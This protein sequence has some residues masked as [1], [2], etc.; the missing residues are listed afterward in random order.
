[1]GYQQRIIGTTTLTPS[2]SID[3]S[4][5]R[6]DQVSEAQSF[7]S[8][9]TRLSFGARLK[10]DV[11][12]FYGGIGSFEAIRH[13]LSPS[14]SYSYAPGV[15][16]TDLQT[17]VFGSRE[18]QTKNVISLSLNQTFEAKRKAEE[19]STAVAGDSLE[20]AQAQETAPGEPRRLPQAEIVNLLSINTSAV[21]FDFT[22]AKEDGSDVLDGF[23]TTRLQNQISSDFLRGLTVSMEHDLFDTDADGKRTFAPLLSQLNFGFQMSNNSGLVRAL[24][25]LLG[26]GGGDEEE[27][28][29][30]DE[31]E[32]E[33]E[34]EEE[35]LFLDDV[36]AVSLTSESTMV[37]G[38]GGNDVIDR[39]A[40]R[41]RGGG[42][43]RVGSW[44]A[45][46]Q[47]SLTRSRM[48]ERPSLQM[49]QA[50]VRFKPTE[51]WDMSWRTSFNV[52]EGTFSDHTIR[53]TRDLHR[54]EA[55]FDFLQTATG[56]WQFRFQVS[57]SDNRDLKFDY[58]QRN[59]DL[60]GRY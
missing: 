35:D 59:A 33:E 36:S 19:D 57:L 58:E 31:P 29:E 17:T 55:N 28:E 51:K 9:P 8:A 6:D 24:G 56:N 4:M 21:T 49:L 2:L 50:N 20:A 30:E 43:G 44:S 39:D 16:P 48:E 23:T 25:G 38:A 40:G 46:M 47:Y 60:E 15:V 26:R 37:P 34:L 52:T 45:S 32:P 1:M 7:V 13:K 22:R 41:R 42:S 10:S 12:G 53:L 3:G 5:K 54:W 14:A 27:E 18:L 11:F